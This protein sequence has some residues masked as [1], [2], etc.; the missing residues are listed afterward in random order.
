QLKAI[1]QELGEKEPDPEDDLAELKKALAKAQP[2]AHV[3]QEADTPPPRRPHRREHP[4][5]AR[6]CSAPARND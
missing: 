3:T 2:P 5:A 4:H 1:R 6:R